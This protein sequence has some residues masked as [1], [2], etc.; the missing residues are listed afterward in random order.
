MSVSVEVFNLGF[1]ASQPLQTI[2]MPR[3]AKVLGCHGQGNGQP[4][5][6][7]RP[8]S[9]FLMASCVLLHALVDSEEAAEARRF[10]VV[11]CGTNLPPPVN[12]SQYVG[13][14]KEWHVFDLDKQ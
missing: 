6:Q 11:K 1:S 10:M 4:D 7:G 14:F 5:D 3:N 12:P 13:H 2:S 8:H 9:R